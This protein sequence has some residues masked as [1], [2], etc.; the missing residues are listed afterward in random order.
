MTV[1]RKTVAHDAF[2]RHIKKIDVDHSVAPLPL[3]PLMVDEDFISMSNCTP[4]GTT[5]PLFEFSV[6]QFI[7]QFINVETP[8]ASE[9]NH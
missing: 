8:V 7:G 3:N 4:G 2:C 1:R 5:G 9:L 6:D